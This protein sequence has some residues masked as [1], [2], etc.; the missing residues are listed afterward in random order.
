MDL[1]PNNAAAEAWFIQ[2]RWSDGV[3][4]HASFAGICHPVRPPDFCLAVSHS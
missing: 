1:F 4:C 3:R 2:H